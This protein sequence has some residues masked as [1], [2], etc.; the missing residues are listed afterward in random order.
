MRCQC[1]FAIIPLMMLPLGTIAAGQD[2]SKYP[3]W[4]GQWTVIVA[5]GLEGQA[6]KFDPTKPWGRGQEAP[7]TAEYQKVHEDSMADQAK[8]G[9]GNYPTATC[10]PGV[11]RYGLSLHPDKTRFVDFRSNR[12]D[13]TNHPETD[14]TSFTFLGFAHIWGKSRVGKNVVRQVTAKNRYARCRA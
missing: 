7:L 5:P 10:H 11:A 3:N 12:P 14:G 4:K 2:A 9:L 13:G 1:S 6:V 8:G